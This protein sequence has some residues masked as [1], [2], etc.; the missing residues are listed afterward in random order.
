MAILLVE[1]HF[2]KWYLY[3]GNQKDS[4]GDPFIAFSSKITV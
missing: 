4:N 3:R 2:G 1:T